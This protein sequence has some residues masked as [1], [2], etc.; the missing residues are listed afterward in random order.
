MTRLPGVTLAFVVLL[1]AAACVPTAAE[2]SARPAVPSAALPTP[3]VS[4]SPQIAGTAALV[5][6]AV[7][8]QGMRLEQ[9]TRAFRASE[10]PT[11]AAAPRAVFQVTLPDEGDGFVVIYEFFDMTTA[12][13][14]GAEFAQFLEGGFGQTNYPLDAQ[15]SLAQ[16][17]GTLIFTSWS[18]QNSSAP[19]QAEAGFKA[20]GS[21]GQPI[22]IIK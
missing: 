20:V 11:I 2:R 3:Q 5:R 8:S 1:A 19:E 18:R 4:L 7:E 6:Q 16:F 14:A 13:A 17:G 22:R 12:A 21:V 9:A 15:F 10:P